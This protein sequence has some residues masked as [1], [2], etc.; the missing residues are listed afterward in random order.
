MTSRLYCERM[1][2]RPRAATIISGFL[3]AATVIAAI[4]GYALLFP[5]ELLRWLA[6][7]NK[8]GIYA[9]EELGSGRDSCC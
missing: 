7:F 2:R 1:V 6:Q 4:V 3:F 8:P 9:F 5:G